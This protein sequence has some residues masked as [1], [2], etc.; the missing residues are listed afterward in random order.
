MFSEILKLIENYLED[1]NVSEEESELIEVLLNEIAANYDRIA[2]F[3]HYARNLS[4][5]DYDL[6][7][8]IFN[9]EEFE[10]KKAI[11]AL[12]ELLEKYK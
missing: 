2:D 4:S 3:S 8:L 11:K 6:N 12:I 7:K 10:S 9:D 1:L 5:L